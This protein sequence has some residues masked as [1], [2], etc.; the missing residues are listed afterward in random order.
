MFKRYYQLAKPGIVYGNAFTTIA[1]YLYA[2]RWHLIGP[3]FAAT[4]AG[5][6]LVIASAAVFNN[7]I[8]RDIDRKM[9]RTRERALVA[10]TISASH[11]LL[12]ATALGLLGAYL[13]WN[14]VNLLTAGVA[15]FGFVFYVAIYGF[16]KRASH[17]GTVVG[18]LSGAMPIV[19]GYTAVTQHFDSQAIILFFIL[20]LWQMP[21]FYAIAMYRL[22]DYVEAGIP[23]LPAKKGMHTTKIYIVCY[24]IAFVAAMASLFV[25][26]HAG[27]IYLAG[28]LMVGV[29]WFLRALH[30][31][32]APDDAAW[33]QKFFLSSLI[34]LVSFCALLSVAAILP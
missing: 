20:A 34:V 14:Y 29:W 32:R 30:G 8:D 28:V 12:Y 22:N 2:S 9:A 10:G 25:L 17:W 15:L 5:I 7:Y 23:V 19:V 6:A 26:G 4:V 21:H 13:L 31:F 1:A 3:L 27:Y 18:S 24:V 11:A 16:A 33:A